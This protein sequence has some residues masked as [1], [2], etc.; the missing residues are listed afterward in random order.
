M[1]GRSTYTNKYKTWEIVV[2]I[3]FEE[4]K[5]ARAFEIYLKR[6]SGHAFA[7]RHSW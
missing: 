6:G 4:E 5:L 2:S 1:Y 7:G 3:W